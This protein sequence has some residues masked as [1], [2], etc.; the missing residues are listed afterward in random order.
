MAAGNGSVFADYEGAR[1]YLANHTSAPASFRINGAS[2]FGQL[3]A[4]RDGGMLLRGHAVSFTG[5]LTDELGNPLNGNVSAQ[6]DMHDLT[7]AA[8]GDGSYRA[9]GTVP[10][11]Y[12]LNHTLTFAWLG[13]EFHT[14]ASGS[15]EVTVYVATQ[16]LLAADPPVA[17]PGDNVTLVVTLQEDDGSLLAG[18][19]VTLEFVLFDQLGQVIAQQNMT[20]VTGAD[21]S[22]SEL[23]EFIPGTEYLRITGGYS[24]S[25]TWV[26]TESST[27]V[28]REV[29]VISG[30]DW[31][32]YLP[33]LAGIPAA[34]MVSGYYLY[35]LQRHKYEVRNLIRNMREQMNEEDDY[36]RIIIQSYFQLTSILERYGFLRRPTQTAREFREVLSRALPISPEGVGLMTQLFEIARYSGV[37]PQ[38]VDEFGMTWSDGSYNLWCAEALDTLHTIE[39]DLEGGLEQGFFSRM[40]R[41]FRRWAT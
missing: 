9:N 23:I 4:S 32:Q 6:L 28:E 19:T 40:E 11:H 3:N 29:V 13:D 2:Q 14:G 12:R 34:L 35:W 33:L 18:K 26:A 1:F 27:D 38:V 36:R 15:L 39:L 41:K 20:R 37:K 5:M 24:G 30:T 21:G 10:A 22:V 31:S 25:G 16:L 17:R 8:L 7:V